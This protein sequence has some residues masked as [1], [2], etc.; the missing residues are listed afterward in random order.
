[1]TKKLKVSDVHSVLPLDEVLKKD[2]GLGKRN[3]SG[4]RAGT[5]L[6]RGRLITLRGLIFAGTKFS[7]FEN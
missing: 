5:N 6:G 3:F 7:G 2:Q 4:A 1:M